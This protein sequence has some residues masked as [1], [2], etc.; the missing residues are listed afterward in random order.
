MIKLGILIV[1]AM[2][3]VVP[4]QSLA[5]SA[6]STSPIDLEQP[7]CQDDSPWSPSKEKFAPDGAITQVG[8]Y[9]FRVCQGGSSTST[10]GNRAMRFFFNPRRVPDLQ[11]DR[12]MIGLMINDLSS[13][14]EK[15]SASLRNHYFQESWYFSEARY[16]LYRFLNDDGSWASSM[17]FVFAPDPSSNVDVPAHMINCS[18]S[19]KDHPAESANCFI[20]VDY[21][22]IFALLLFIGGGPEFPEIPVD[23]FPELARDV[24][25]ILDAANVTDEM[26]EMALELPFLP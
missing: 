20:L 9:F 16:D 14:D 3:L 15:L 13:W 11:H 24:L 1:M 23:D 12:A 6:S 25:R 19:F 2:A 7:W 17:T 5:D 4:S 10:P 22:E 8:P 26:N 21:N 18:G